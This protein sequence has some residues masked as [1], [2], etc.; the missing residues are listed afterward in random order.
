MRCGASEGVRDAAFVPRSEGLKT[1]DRS[2]VVKVLFSYYSNIN[3][4]AICMLGNL[5]HRCGWDVEY[6]YFPD[7]TTDQQIADVLLDSKPEV[8]GISLKTFERRL[9]VKTA[10]IAKTMSIKV[11][12]G[13]PHATD[14]PDDLAA[15]GVFDAIVRG[16]GMGV[17]E[18]LLGSHDSLRGD[19]ILGTR[20]PDIAL[21]SQR[22]FDEKQEEEIRETKMY[23]AMGSL[24]CPFKCTYC[25]TSRKV[26]YLPPIDVVNSIAEGKEKYGIELVAFL[27]DTYSYSL[28]KLREFH[29]LIRE[30]GL[31]FEY[32]QVGTRVDCLTDEIADELMTNGVEEIAFGVETASPKLLDFLEKGCTVEQTYRAAE[33]CKRHGISMKINLMFGFP[34]QDQEDYEITHQYVQETSPS[35]I[36]CFY[37]TPFPNTKLFQYCLENDYMPDNWSYDDYLSLDMNSRD[38]RGYR[39]TPG[40]LKHIDYEMAEYYYQRILKHESDRID[41]SIMDAA[42][43]ADQAPWIVVGCRKY[44]YVVL[45]RLSKRKWKN[46]LGFHNIV[47]DEPVKQVFE[48][49][50]PKIDP[51]TAWNNAKN[52]IVTYHKGYYYYNNILPMLKD[53]F[54]FHGDIY[55]ASTY[56]E[57]FDYPKAS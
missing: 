13:G 16:D 2:N 46:L 36:N 56:P 32:S 22:Y 39:E 19:I 35:S 47:E 29:N 6:R 21:Y 14:A 54:Q 9:A 42:E 44:F 33:I 15:L 55:S 57:R 20:H 24:G 27:D 5:A 45:E 12:A 37:F 31:N 48:I 38:F 34:R 40:N 26:G 17:L 18:N 43:K 25:A 8:L 3:S 41:Q 49:N 30:R 10:S 28:K 53:K 23:H 11:I 51:H 1:R 7:D 52:I 4:Y 50:I